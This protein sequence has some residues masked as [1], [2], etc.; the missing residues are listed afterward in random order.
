LA[1]RSAYTRAILRHILFM[2]VKLKPSVYFILVTMMIDSI[3]LGIIIPVFPKLIMGMEQCDESRA[4][5]IG[6]WMMFWFALMQFLISPILGNLS[7]RYGRRPILLLSLFGF[8][9]DYLIL[10][11]APTVGWLY[12]GRILAGIMGAS[13]TTATAYI[14]D[15]STEE[16]RSKYYGM[17]GA[18]FGLGFI[19]GPGVGGLLQMFG[20]RVPF[21]AG[22]V[23]SFLNWIYGYFILPESLSMKE[24]RRFDIKRAN[25]IGAFRHLSQYRKLFGLLAAFFL[26]YLA[27]QAVMSNWQY[28]TILKF[29]WDETKIGLSITLIGIMVALVQGLLVRYINPKIGN[30]NAVLV[31]LGLYTI[32][33]LSFG[34]APTGTWMIIASIPYCLG[35]INGPAMQTIMSSSVAKNAQGELQGMITSV[36]SITYIIGPVMMAGIFEYFTSKSTYY[37]PGAAFVAAAILVFLALI[38]SYFSLEKKMTDG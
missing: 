36:M 22:A 7:D 4:A 8:G 34:L 30:K 20:E 31:G 24:R 25:P 10:A 29:Q 23:L 16:T 28:Y 26:L 12:V 11:F 18:A 33:L 27:A 13:Y 21:I 3:S 35:G 17:L 9:I 38:V 14:A 32:G 15:I 37:F 2:S 1:I 19:I 6:S 5:I